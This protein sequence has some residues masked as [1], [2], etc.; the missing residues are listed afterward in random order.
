MEAIVAVLLGAIEL[1]LYEDDHIS[2]RKLL[3]FFLIAAVV[4]AILAYQLKLM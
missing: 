1:M 4:L 3:L 2:L